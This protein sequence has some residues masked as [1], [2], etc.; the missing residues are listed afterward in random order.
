MNADRTLDVLDYWNLRAAGW[1]VIPVCQQATG[2]LSLQKWVADF[3]EENSFAFRDNPNLFN[4]TLLLKSRSLSPL[5]VEK[6]GRALKLSPSTHRREMKMVYHLSYPRIW[7]E[8]ARERDEAEPC[9]IEVSTEEHQIKPADEAIT[10]RSLIPEFASRLGGHDKPRCANEIE[11]RIWT[12][13]FIP[14]EVIPEG[15]SHLARSSVPFAIGEWRCAKTGLVYLPAHK[16]WSETLALISA[17]SV[18]AA[19][20]AAKGWKVE[21]SNNGQIANQMLKHLGGVLVS[22]CSQKGALSDS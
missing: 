2:N 4:H 21:L 13:D 9:G 22:R 1:N 14:A 15:D 17:E 16:E 11:L 6:F 8:W 7:D 12:N 19:W 18:F 5:D 20:L 10:F 3:V